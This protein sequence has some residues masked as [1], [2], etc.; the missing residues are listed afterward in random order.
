M[1]GSLLTDNNNSSHPSCLCAKTIQLSCFGYLN[2][3]LDVMPAEKKDELT[4]SEREDE[5]PNWDSALQGT[6]LYLGG[7]GY[8]T[9]I[10]FSDSY[11][12]Y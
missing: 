10:S 8:E 11:M 12:H 5:G 1:I 4:H 9:I 7:L 6:R 3:R 2:P